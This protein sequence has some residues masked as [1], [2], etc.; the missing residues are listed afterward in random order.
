MAIVQL[1]ATLRRRKNKELAAKDGRQDHASGGFRDL[2]DWMGEPQK[3]PS[4]YG[5]RLKGFL[6]YDLPRSHSG[7]TRVK[8]NISQNALSPLSLISGPLHSFPIPEHLK[9][10]SF[11]KAQPSLESYRGPTVYLIL[12][13]TYSDSCTGIRG[14][15]SFS[16]HRVN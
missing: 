8:K 9:P 14:L 3:G 11:I 10:H 4:Y 1:D 12:G 5:T 15:S 7:P 6:L 2:G 16:D 13:A